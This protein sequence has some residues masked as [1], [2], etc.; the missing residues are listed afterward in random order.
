MS[1]SSCWSS[2]KPIATQPIV[3]GAFTATVTSWK[4][5][6]ASTFTAPSSAAAAPLPDEA[7]RAPAR[8]S[9]STSLESPSVEATG[10]NFASV[11]TATLAPMRSDWLR[12]AS[13]RVSRSPLAMAER[14]P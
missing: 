10:V 8:I 11:N 2:G 4:G 5:L 12:S 7:V 9:A 6:P 1:V 3:L 14:K 13:F